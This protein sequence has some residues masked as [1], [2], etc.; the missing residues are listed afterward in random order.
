MSKRKWGESFL[1]S[2]LP[3]EH[4]A[5]AEF[6]NLGWN[7]TPHLEVLRS[8]TDNDLTW[9]E[10]DFEADT[11]ESNEDTDL[12]LLVE[13]KYHDPSRFW[14]FLP[15]EANRWAFDDRVLNI[16]PYQTLGDPR[17]NSFLDLAPVSSSGIVLSESG[18][19][20]ENA[21]QKAVYQIAEALVPRCLFIQ[22]EYNL[23][24]PSRV[25]P[26]CAA[27]IPCIVTNAGLFRMR[28]EIVRLDDIR[29]ASSPGDIADEVPWTWCYFDAPMDIVE[30]HHI[31]IDAHES[32]NEEILQRFPETVARMRELAGRPNWIAVINIEHLSSAVM[33]IHNRFLACSIRTVKAVFRKERSKS[34][35]RK[36]LK[37]EHTIQEELTSHT[38]PYESIR[39]VLAALTPRQEKLL[40]IIYGIGESERSIEDAAEQ[41]NL[42]VQEAEST[43]TEAMKA[44]GNADSLRVLLRYIG[45]S[46]RD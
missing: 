9:F 7:I 18:E 25:P 5:M 6:R 15:H 10:I 2:G 19:K 37:L 29:E 22:Y 13:C 39:K 16:G 17:A 21:F 32:G 20:Q 41:L 11:P 46:R 31:S 35:K 24:I 40:R 12:F 42:S 3:L 28:H 30:H 34:R 14:M 36:T 4:L 26:M 23:D 1:K 43:Y 27:V 38:A 45:Q 33:A 8:N 44:L